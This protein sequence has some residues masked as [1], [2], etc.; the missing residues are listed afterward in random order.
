MSALPVHEHPIGDG[1]AKRSVLAKSRLGARKCVAH[2]RLAFC[3]RCKR[4]H[5]GRARRIIVTDKFDP[6]AFIRA[7]EEEV[8]RH[9][10]FP[11]QSVAK[12]RLH[13]LSRP[14]QLRWHSDRSRKR[15]H[16]REEPTPR[17]FHD[18]PRRDGSKIARADH[19]E[20][21]ESVRVGFAGEQVRKTPLP[22]TARLRTRWCTR[23]RSTTLLA[24]SSPIRVVP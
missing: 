2:R 11:A 3:S 20:S 19:F 24:G 15:G 13:S 8:R 21:A 12:R 22:S 10:V 6:T 17:E 18:V 9:Q 5:A 16:Y 4:I 14:E 7:V 1:R 23:C